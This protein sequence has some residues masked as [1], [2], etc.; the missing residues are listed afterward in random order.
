[1]TD[2]QANQAAK[3]NKATYNALVD[4]FESI[5]H[6]LRRLDIY[7]QTQ[8]SL[9]P[10]MYEIVGKIMVEL[11]STLAL[12]TNELKRRRSSESVPADLLPP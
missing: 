1:M 5:E 8:I 10:A 3:D 4:L 11:L 9:T 12:A 7:T 6:F 2:I